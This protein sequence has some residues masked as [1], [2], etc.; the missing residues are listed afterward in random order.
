MKKS[1][2][3]YVLLPILVILSF[4][5]IIFNS[6]QPHKV[7]VEEEAFTKERKVWEYLR[8]R[9]PVTGKIPS[10][11][12]AKSIDFVNNLKLKIK[13][14]DK[15][16]KNEWQQRG[17]FEVGG[18]T[19]ALA[20]DVTDENIIIA[21]AVSGGMWRSTDAGVTWSKTTRPDQLHSISCVAQDT[22]EGKENIWY[23]GT[24]EFWGNSADLNGN[25]IYKST[26]NGKTWF[27]LESTAS[28]TPNRWDGAFEYVWNIKINPA[29]PNDIDE[30]LASTALGGVFRSTDG[31]ETWNAVLGSYGNDYSYFTD[32]NIT[33]KGIY[34]A[35]LSTTNSQTN[36]SRVSGIFRSI[37]G[38]DWINIAPDN[39]QTITKR[40]VIG[41]APSDEDQVYFIG[42]TPNFGK[43][44]T[45]SRGDDMWHSLWK[46]TY[47]DDD[48]SGNGGIWEDRSDNIPAPELIRGHFN[49]Q[50][51]YNLCIAVKP[52][53]PETVFIG[54]VALYRSDNGWRTDD[55]TWIGGTCPDDDCEYFYRYP[56]HHADN[57]VLTFLPSN[58]NI[59]YTGSDGGVHKT[60]DSKADRV[61]W[62]SLNNGYYTTQFYSIAIDHGNNLSDNVIGGLQDNGTLLSLQNDLNEEWK[63][64]SRADGFYCAIPDGSMYF[65]S[66][67]NSTYQPKIKIWRTVLN[68]DGSNKTQTRIDPIG[69]KDF[70]WNTPFILDPNDNNIMYLAG[71]SIVWRNNNLSE[72]P[73][74]N[75]LDS[76]SI[77]WDSLSYTRVDLESAGQIRPESVT[78]INVST[79]PA[80][81]LYYGT[82]YGRVFRLDNSNEGDPIPVEI[83]S[84]LFPTGYVSSIAIDPD[85][86]M[87][88]IVSYSNYNVLSMF[89]S[90]DGGN[91]WD[92]VSGNLEENSNGTGAGPATLWVEILKVNEQ[93]LYLVGTSAGL[94]STSYVNKMNTIWVQESPELIGNMVIDMIDVRHQDGFVAVGTHGIGT[95]VSKIN[96]LPD[97]PGAV[98]LVYPVNSTN[99]IKNS[100]LFKWNELTS[101]PVTYKIEFSQTPD[102]SE[103]EIEISGIRS[104]SAFVSGFQQG[105]QDYYWRVQTVGNGGLGEYS[106]T[107]KF[108]TAIGSPELISPA[109]GSTDNSIHTIFNWNSVEKATSYRI[110]LTSST[111]FSGKLIIDEIVS[112]N[113]YKVFDLKSFFNYRWR[114][115]SIDEFGE[116]EFS[117]EYT[118]R[119][120]ATNSVNENSSFGINLF[121]NPAK[122]KLNISLKNLKPGNLSIELYSLDGK[123]I[124]KLFDSSITGN[125]YK[126]DFDI[127]KFKSGSYI[128][129]II[130][131]NLSQS[132]VILFTK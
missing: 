66:S 118:F 95:F 116:G 33:Q 84:N 21:G 104:D 105:F 49:S 53:D 81:I 71:G 86:A 34:Y 97:K 62:I 3:L 26:D 13:N 115:A 124:A 41:I 11:I 90:T 22:R 8:Y 63:T 125:S 27:I 79:S 114:V 4:L 113:G 83:T 65:Y 128:I 10:N 73:F 109:N 89:H 24:G 52:D 75:S 57:H 44:T 64:P 123:K 46:Y 5:F 85:D 91:N 39:F 54:G 126:S 107:W 25:G 56:N 130:N 9:D 19:R 30:I 102:F 61:E 36:G 50:G 47:L 98:S 99:N 16:Q 32:I 7:H 67:Q 58:P 35:T 127:E 77:N 40:I 93:K 119:V 12:H 87:N 74:E 15:F 37:N 48:G 70:I 94:F 92:P 20:I 106:E 112:N 55:F 120:D 122:N 78:A 6:P 76:T 88:V 18:R 117:E 100:Q 17:P 23:A 121:P 1:I 111:S 43:W 28:N 132:K 60:I 96:S 2:T 101:E 72:I 31:G 29:A 131:A 68:E 51:S 14:F 129:K 103:I 38:V 69:G 82:S 45:N 59:L 42:E 108:S 110:Q 80:N